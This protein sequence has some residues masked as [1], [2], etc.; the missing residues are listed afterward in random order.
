MS[1]VKEISVIMPLYNKERH[2]ERAVRSI[3]GQT[4]QP[5]EI[6]VVNDGSTD[7]SVSVVEKIVDPRIRIINQNNAGVSAAR[8]RGIREA[9]FALVAMLDSDDEWKP[10]FLE[11]ILDLIERFPE[12][13][14][15]A[16]A[17]ET[18]D[19]DAVI[20]KVT[21]RAI[22]EF[23]WSGIIP[24]FF[25]SMLGQPPVWASAVTVRREVFN[26]S[27]FF[28]EGEVLAE[29]VDMWCRIALKYPVAFNTKACAV[30]HLE[31]DNRCYTRGKINKKATGYIETLNA[32]KQDKSLPEDVRY[33][34]SVLRETV[35][36]GYAASLIFGRETKAAR[37]VLK[38]FDCVH[39]KKKKL[40]WQVFSYFPVR[41]LE[42]LMDAKNR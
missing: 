17:Y 15:F 36:L 34:I 30:Y 12:A 7:K 16:T 23:P 4:V 1:S 28:R 29:D 26:K 6:I 35:E 25:D 11:T 13:G 20:R 2:V 31:A 22:P 24:N 32:A 38:E 21:Y 14:A 5:A 40:M 19:V 27:G 33:N 41:L 39:L 9:K 3:L 18:I 10:D 37:K 42:I 8:N